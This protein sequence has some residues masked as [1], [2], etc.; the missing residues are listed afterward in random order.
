MKVLFSGGLGN[1]MF[2]YA[3]YYALRKNNR[4]V[5]VDTCLYSHLEMHNGF[6]ITKAFGIDI[7]LK[8]Y[9]KLYITYI[10]LLLKLKPSKVLNI[11]KSYFEDNFIKTNALYHYGYWQSEKYFKSIK[12]E[13]KEIYT[14][15]NI[16][17]VNLDLS[18][19]INSENSVSLHIRRGDYIGNTIYEGVCT[20]DY[21]SK[22]IE[23]I[24]KN[25]NNAIFYVFSDNIIEA[26]RLIS[27]YNI[28][29]IFVDI[30]TN[31]NS[32]LDMFLMSCC[33][34][35]I[36][37]NSTFSWWGAWLNKNPNKIII[38]PKKWINDDESKFKDIVP[39]N[40]LKI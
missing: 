2:Q 25:V 18:K 15:R 35:N 11:D 27:K 40:W 28:K 21:Y 16:N 19:K 33:K 38:A 31:V 30:N 17:T 39:N 6:E 5:E 7:P 24:N 4:K 14:F 29:T 20:D 36:I 23:H 13:I 3:F 22:A 32:Y 9:S 37:A 26:K 1:Q 12:D 8:Y 34:H 10:R